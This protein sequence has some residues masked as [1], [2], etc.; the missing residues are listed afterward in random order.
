ML[1]ESDVAR[2]SL[3]FSNVRTLISTQYNLTGTHELVIKGGRE[4]IK[5]WISVGEK[6]NGLG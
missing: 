5:A 3:Y 1:W 4:G 2:V 6:R